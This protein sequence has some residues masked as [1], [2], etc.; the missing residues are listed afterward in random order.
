MNLDAK[1]GEGRGK[2][3]EEGAYRMIGTAGG[4]KNT[5]R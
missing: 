5:S 4:V 2:R 1:V 3:E